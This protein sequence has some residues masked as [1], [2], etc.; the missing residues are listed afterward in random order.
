MFHHHISLLILQRLDDALRLLI[1]MQED[2]MIAFLIVTLK[3]QC[4]YLA[5]KAID[6]SS[7]VLLLGLEIFGMLFLTLS[8]CQSVGSKVSTVHVVNTSTIKVE[9]TQLRDSAVTAFVA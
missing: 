7:V 3:L 5:F 8:R 6:R 9:H 2:L 1:S 4:L